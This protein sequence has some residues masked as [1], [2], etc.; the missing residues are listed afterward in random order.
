[1]NFLSKLFG[2][3]SPLGEEPIRLAHFDVAGWEEVERSP[4]CVYYQTPDNV[5]VSITWDP[6][7]NYAQLDFT[8]AIAVRRDMRETMPKYGLVSCDGLAI[9]GTPAAHAILK[10]EDGLGF[11]YAAMLVVPA[12][13]GAFLIYIAANEGDFTGTREALATAKLLGEGK[14]EFEHYEHKAADGST[15]RIKNWYVDP[16]EPGYPGLVL[17]SVSDD[18]EYDASLPDHPLTKVRRVLAH[19]VSTLR[20]DPGT[21]RP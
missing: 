20:F 17:R 15:G 1:M 10:R 3:N 5:A 6:F 4:N 13:D 7:E 8:D 9:C 18:E 14:I 11:A 16:Y 21:L 2:G 19:T 12:R